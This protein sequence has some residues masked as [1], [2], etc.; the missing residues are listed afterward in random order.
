M[1]SSSI[2]KIILIIF[3]ILFFSTL[4]WYFY[5]PEV[6]MNN[7]D[8]YG[9]NSGIFSLLP[10]TGNSIINDS[11]K[12]NEG[13]GNDGIIENKNAENDEDQIIGVKKYEMP[14]IRQISNIPTA[15]AFIQE[16]AR[17]Q[18]YEIN[19]RMKEN[20][21]I[22]NE[23]IYSEIRYVS[24][25]NNHVYQTYD[26][27]LDSKRISNVTIPKIFDA[28]F[29]DI[30]NYLIR[31]KNNFNLVKTYSIT[32][33]DKVLK[34]E[35]E[36]NDLGEK[37]FQGIFLPDNIEDF[38][39]LSNQKKIAYIKKGEYENKVFLINNK[40]GNQVEIGSI[41][42]NEMN[43]IFNNP[44]KLFISNKTANST[45][46]LSFVLGIN[47]KNLEIINYPIKAGY[48]LPN[49]DF[50]KI[51]YSGI[52]EYSDKFKLFVISN[53]DRSTRIFN[54]KTLADK[55]I[56][57]KDNINIYC[58]IPAYLE[59]D[60]PD[61]WYKGK[62]YFSDEIYKINTNNGEEEKVFIPKDR[63]HLFDIT[64]LNLNNTERYIY[65]KDKKT[66]FYWSIN[67]E[68]IDS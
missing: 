32:L 36:E 60:G 26:F 21:K 33:S 29:F 3:F 20:E 9:E 37:R 11:S 50:S 4:G 44:N 10:F 24:M 18:I 57:S 30:D 27:T 54:S 1:R 67:I 64:D 55:C 28:Q 2:V 61:D 8:T 25:K 43:I 38:D 52:N 23:G 59:K 45:N 47:D 17:E 65:F 53:N 51:L 16:L 41:E 5:E 7:E 34:Y 62:K 39:I 48:G 40:G 22:D 12:N 63:T 31:Y 42:L 66:D 58:A 15:G 19:G 56:W 68:N 49:Y 46:T 35:A 6:N 13:A 14:I